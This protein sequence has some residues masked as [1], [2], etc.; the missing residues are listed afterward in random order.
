MLTYLDMIGVAVLVITVILVA[1][2]YYEIEA[3]KHRACKPKKAIGYSP[4]EHRIYP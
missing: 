2:G 1:M 3:R 4:G